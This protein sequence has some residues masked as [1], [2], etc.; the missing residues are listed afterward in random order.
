MVRRRTREQEDRRDDPQRVSVSTVCYARTMRRAAVLVLVA[1]CHHH[2]ERAAPVTPV[3]PVADDVVPELSC[4]AQDR[5]SK[6]RGVDPQQ[7]GYI[8]VRDLA[9]L[10]RWR[11]DHG[12][13]ALANDASSRSTVATWAAFDDLRA[14]IQ[15]CMV[16]A[17]G[18]HPELQ[19]E[20]NMA[21]DAS[22]V[23]TL[24]TGVSVQRIDGAAA[25]GAPILGK[26]GAEACVGDL[27]GRLVLPPSTY[28]LGRLMTVVRQD[29]CTP[30]VEIALNAT[31]SYV[32]AYRTWWRAHRDRVCPVS[33]SELDG[34]GRDHGKDPWHQPYE[35]RCDANGFEV[36]S[37]G[38][39][40][41]IGTA[42][43][44]SAHR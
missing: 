15:K 17:D 18:A 33:L 31:R 9:E 40:R 13:V 41:R 21:L 23:A 10:E 26:T 35:M 30:T 44:L 20:M 25:D 3:H 42:D 24:I 19:Y 39:D 1:A 36:I 22:S 14:D 37:G 38:P 29:F 34:Y 7:G 32:D 5:P 28:G 4:P 12:A 11:A 8:I 43:D 27:L 6:L 2:D 16:S